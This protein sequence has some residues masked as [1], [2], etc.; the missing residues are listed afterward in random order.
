MNKQKHLL[1][2]SQYFY[3]EQFRINDICKEW[4]KRG[5]EVTVITGIP[6]YPHGKYYKGYGVLK[7][8]RSNYEGVN[9]IRIPLIPRGHNAIMLSLNY[10]SFVISGFIWNA[11]TRVKADYVFIYE[12]SPMTQ[13]LPGIWYAKKKNIPCYLYVTDLWPENIESVAGVHNSFI[14]KPIEKM[15]THIYRKCTKI[16]TSSNSFI[17]LIENKGIE[18]E[19]LCFWPQYAEEFYSPRESRIQQDIFTESTF[20]IIFAGNIGYAQGL[21]ILPAVVEKLRK[22]HIKVC[23]CMIGDGRYKDILINSIA[24][25]KMQTY[26]KFINKQPAEKIPEYMACADAALITLSQSDVFARTIPAKLQSC[27]ACG[28]PIILSADGEVQ[29]IVSESQCGLVS[30]A[31]EIDGL[32]KNIKLMS[33]FPKETLNMMARNAIGYSQ[34][35]FNKEVLMN[36]MD[37]YFGG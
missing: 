35:K 2:I 4:V 36:E 22:S 15:V 19:K 10:I 32:V 28:I 33:E 31:G 17:P 27:M 18:K 30:A 14:I 34:K 13:A 21:D 37:F 16:F 11:L 9:I 7:N 20:N 25:R 8:C 1:V 5:Y 12:V 26:F 23:F 24:E 29:E 3:P 6:N